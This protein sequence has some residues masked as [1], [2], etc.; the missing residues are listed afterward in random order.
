MSD[1]TAPSHDILIIQNSVNDNPGECGI[2]LA[3]HPPVGAIGSKHHGVYHVTVDDNDVENNGVQVG[4]AGVGIFSD[5]I[6]PAGLR[7]T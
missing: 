7:E 1:E 5:G 2:V 4:G 6:G 3:S